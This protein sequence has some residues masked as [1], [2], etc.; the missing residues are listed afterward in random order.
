MTAN[1]SASHVDEWVRDY[2][3]RLQAEIAKRRKPEGEDDDPDDEIAVI[4]PIPNNK[5]HFG[6]FIFDLVVGCTLVYAQI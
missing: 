5:A 1:S 3:S 6:M 4:C 2:H